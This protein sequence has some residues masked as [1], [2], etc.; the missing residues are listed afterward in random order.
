MVKHLHR[1]RRHEQA[2]MPAL[3]W[4]RI[5]MQL[6]L[7]GDQLREYN[8]DRCSFPIESDVGSIMNKLSLGALS[9]SEPAEQRTLEVS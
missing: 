6:A 4:L 8:E 1:R 5:Y 3:V 2:R 7:P 9:R